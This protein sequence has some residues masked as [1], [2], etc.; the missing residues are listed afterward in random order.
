MKVKT[1]FK[2]LPLACL[3]CAGMAIAKG[4]VEGTIQ[5]YVVVQ[6]ENGKEII[7]ETSSAVPGQV[8]EYRLRFANKGESDVRGLKIVD[9]IPVQTIFIPDSNSTSVTSVFEVS[10]D[11][12]K[13]FES[14]PVKRIETKA[15]GTQQEVVVPPEQYTHLRWNAADTLNSNGGTQEYA[16]RVRVK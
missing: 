6:D 11:G 10:I 9:P 4:P 13:T 5:A 3:L 1:L 7:Q 16:Y 15:D 8:M 14:I 12:G 2:T